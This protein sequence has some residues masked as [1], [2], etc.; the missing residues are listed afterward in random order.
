MVL[1]PGWHAPDFAMTLLGKP[2]SFRAWREGL[3]CVFVTN[4]HGF[5][6]EP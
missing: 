4:P 2:T 6:A 5:S 1:F 3:W